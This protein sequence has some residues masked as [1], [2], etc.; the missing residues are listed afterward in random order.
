M[1]DFLLF[2]LVGFCAQIVDGA[3][4][5]AYGVISM[6]V[7]M[8]M[9]IPPATGSAAIHT[10][11]IFTTGVSGLSH[12]MFKNVDYKLLRRLILPGI[13]GCICGALMLSY[14]PEKLIKPFIAAYL[15]ILGGIIFYK[16][17]REMPW[18]L[19]V[20]NLVDRALERDKPSHSWYRTIPLGLVGGFSDAA[21]GG[22]WG[23]IVATTLLA[24]DEED[25][26]HTIGTTNLSEFL[27]A[28]T[29]AITFSAAIGISHWRIVLGLIC[30][31]VIA[32]PLAAFAVRYIPPKVVMFTVGTVIMSISLFTY[33]KLFLKA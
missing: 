25:P 11:E 6:S 29:A 32:A 1:E 4:G 31:G 28:L 30:G 16:A 9:G 12:A 13:I 33:Y 10:A 19:R 27:I 21:G 26:R 3:L 22:G 17:I 23:G 20:K 15:F 14:I 5:M 24:Q 2:M 8:G 18:L 7:L